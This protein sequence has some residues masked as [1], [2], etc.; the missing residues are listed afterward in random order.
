LEIFIGSFND[1]VVGM[2]TFGK[3][4]IFV[5]PEKDILDSEKRKD[6]FFFYLGLTQP[7]HG[8][9]RSEMPRNASW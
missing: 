5:V 3:T 1:G 7:I 9:K 8:K 2:A 4:T 6:S